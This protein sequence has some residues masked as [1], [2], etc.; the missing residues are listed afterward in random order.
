MVAGSKK[1]AG[2]G[3]GARGQAF[4]LLSRCFPSALFMHFAIVVVA[5][6]RV[7]VVAV[8]WPTHTLTLTHSYTH[9]HT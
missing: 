2:Q 8:Y 3:A 6:V 1:G 9:T 5:V 4:V 7:V